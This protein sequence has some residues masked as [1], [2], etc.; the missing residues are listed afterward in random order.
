MPETSEKGLTAAE[1]AALT[2]SGQVNAV[3]SS[4]SRSFADIVRANVFT[5]F[6]GIIFAAMVMVLVTGSW[7]DAVFGLVILI[8]TGIGI[9]TELKAKRTLDKLSILV[10]SDYLV[11]RDGKDVEL[12]DC[13][14]Q[15]SASLW[16]MMAEEAGDPLPFPVTPANVAT[17]RMSGRRLKGAEDK[18][19]FIDCPPNGRV[20]DEAADCSDLIVV[21]TT[22]GPADMVKTFETT[23]TLGARGFLFAILLTRV[24]PGTLSLKQSLGELA[25]RDTSYFDYQIP[26][27]EGL[28]NFFGNSFGDDLYGYEKVYEQ[29]KQS[30]KEDKEAYGAN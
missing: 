27:R 12:Y 10:A 25:D 1:V 8:N 4:T 24:L 16:A 30:I 18:W 15:S 19:L 3:K 9:I 17:V 6:N 23:D 2:E 28:K 11:R 20:M 22:T 14:P 21:P 26:S 13:D 5:L 29:I 7:R